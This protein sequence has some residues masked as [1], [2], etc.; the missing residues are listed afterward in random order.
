MCQP[1][2]N[3]NNGEVLLPIADSSECDY[4]Y[5]PAEREVQFWE[6]GKV[7]DAVKVCEDCYFNIISD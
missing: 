4:C 6:D 5:A 7:D 2:S 3:V 1:I